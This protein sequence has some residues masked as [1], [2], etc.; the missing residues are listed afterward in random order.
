[1]RLRPFMP[2]SDGTRLPS[3]RL[4]RI[5]FGLLASQMGARVLAFALYLWLA[6]VLP[7]GDTEPISGLSLYNLS[8]STYGLLMAVVGDAGL[9]QLTLVAMGRRPHAA[10][11]L[12]GRYMVARGVVGVVVMMALLTWWTMTGRYGDTLIALALGTLLT[13]VDALNQ[14]IKTVLRGLEDT[15]LDAAGSLLGRTASIGFVAVL[16]LSGVRDV[17][18]IL[19]VMLAAFIIETY[20]LVRGLRLGG[21]A[22]RW[23]RA[24]MLVVLPT[25]RAGMPFW[26][27]AIFVEIMRRGPFLTLESWHGPLAYGLA[28]NSFRLYE[29]A[30]MVPVFIVTAFYTRVLRLADNRA[31]DARAAFVRDAY[32]AMHFLVLLLLAGPL[33]WAALERDTLMGILFKPE[34]APG[35]PAFAMFTIW[36]LGSGLSNLVG[37]TLMAAGHARVIAM[38]AIGSAAASGLAIWQLL[39]QE[40][41]TLDA[42]TW[43]LRTATIMAISEW[44]Y[45]AFVLAA[46][47]RFKLWP[48]PWGERRAVPLATRL[49]LL[50]GSVGVALVGSVVAR[51]GGW[52]EVAM[53]VV[54]GGTQVGL[55][56]MGLRKVRALF[57]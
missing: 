41:H 55:W 16:L 38:C 46:A 53:W 32:G 6:R 47:M 54:V 45:Y 57:R 5:V 20:Y 26:V 2:P 12:L 52:V 25:L 37:N 13:S 18:V 49:A 17:R 21:V 31:P 34:Y 42:G 15:K 40:T 9:R 8:V 3:S 27:L 22:I 43:A 51:H 29:S 28:S 44:V 7:L 36:L 4:G 33:L 14:Q 24:P 19:S 10:N 56:A 39:G 50:G 30:M 11:R 23:P 1:M 48:K 35:A